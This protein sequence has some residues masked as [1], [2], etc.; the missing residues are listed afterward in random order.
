MDL[1][2]GT[3]EI[4]VSAVVISISVPGNI[5]LIYCTR[6]CIDEQLRT[7]FTLIFSLAWTNLIYNLVV[8]I[9]KIVYASNVELDSAVCKVLMFTAVFTT[10]LAIWFTLYIALLFCSKLCRVVHPPVEAACKNYQK[11]HMVLVFTLWVAGVA[12]CCPVLL[13]TRR[14]EKLN[15][16]NETY[17]QF[18]SL[19]YTECKTEYRNDLIEILYGKIFLGAINL[20]PLL[21]ML[22]T[23]F[24]IVYLL[25][26]H[27]K[28]TY[29]GIWIGGDASELEVVR[30]CKIILLLIFVITSFCVSYFSLVYCLK[31]FKSCYFAPPVLTVL[32]SGYSSVSPYLLMLINYKVIVRMRCFCC[33]DE[34]K[35][36]TVS[37]IAPVSPYA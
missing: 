18:S 12:V 28:A 17:Q 4:V 2:G 19:I 27:R 31:N 11:F 7:S 29:G 34:K 33:K 6:R 30:A 35:L 32:S 20:L 13:Y 14:I 22:L 10:S 3:L 1:S 16:E 24:R 36:V 25:W 37:A 23:G 21:I 8:N 26:E 15:T 5:L 9:L